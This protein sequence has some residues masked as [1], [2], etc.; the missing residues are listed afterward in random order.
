MFFAASRT[1]VSVGRIEAN[2]AAPSPLSTASR[3]KYSVYHAA[4]FSV[5]LSP[6]RG[7][8]PADDGRHRAEKLGVVRDHEEVERGLDLHD[9]AVPRVDHREALRIAIRGV[10]IRGR[11]RVQI[12]VEGVRGVEVRVPP[13]ELLLGGG[14]DRGGE[15][16]EQ[17]GGDGQGETGLHG[18]PPG[19][20]CYR[21]SWVVPALERGDDVVP[22]L[23]MRRA[24][25]RQ[26]DAVG[27]A[28][29]ALAKLRRDRLARADHGDRLEDLVA[30][31][32]GHVVPTPLLGE[33]VQLGVELAPAVRVEGRSVGRR[34][35]VEGQ[36]LA[37]GLT[38]GFE[39]LFSLRGHD[40][41]RG[42]DFDVVAGATHLRKPAFEGGQRLRL[43]RVPRRERVREEAVRDLA[44]PLAHPRP[45][46]TDEDRRR[47]V[48]VR[49]GIE[50]RDHDRVA[51]ELALEAQRGAVL[52][53]VEDRA[54]REHE[55]PH[56]R[57][58]P[59]PRHRE[60]ALDVRADLRTES[61]QEAPP[62]E[63]LH[64]VGEVREVHRA[65]RERDRDRGAEAQPLGAIRRP[66]ERQE[67][68]VLR[69]EAERPVVA[70]RLEPSEVLPHPPRI[71]ERRNRVH[72]HGD[73]PSV[74]PFFRSVMRG[75]RTGSEDQENRNIG[76]TG[77]T[78]PPRPVRRRRSGC[79]G[80]CGP[81]IPRT[82]RSTGRRSARAPASPR[83]SRGARVASSCCRGGSL[84]GP[85]A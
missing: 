46:A 38:H 82:A 56:A 58:G 43:E 47:P 27:D 52:P 55:L 11:V 2:A 31:E 9:R 78:S 63:G 29:E 72:L 40:H 24:V 17:G 85:G 84:R 57:R 1:S 22:E 13:Q 25:V 76:K 50:G 60:A 20:R 16:A 5:K 28:V 74:V 33:P 8:P 79:R 15:H 70:D 21:S 39:L 48:R 73:V 80:R 49:A 67:R 65:A 83:R 44:D 41:R 71:L 26:A 34:R 3:K 18:R 35:A 12:R 62:G 19:R 10:R 14:R 68:I 23:G 54:D 75:P 81:G 64:P 61:E 53:G 7:I 42:D 45:E 69:L 59:R 51:E 6:S 77:G 66:H 32:A 37:R 4:R 30:D 36:V